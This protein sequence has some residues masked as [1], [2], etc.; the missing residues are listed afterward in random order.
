MFSLVKP[1]RIMFAIGIIALAILSF[2]MHDFIVGRPPAW[3]AGV[4][5]TGLN[6]VLAGI[7]ILCGLAIIFD[8]GGR[9]GAL[10]I[11]LVILISSFLIRYL[12]SLIHA[13]KAEDI[14]W[15]LNAYKTLALAGS[16]FIVAASFPAGRAG[17]NEKLALAGSILLA[18][19]LVLGG[20]SHFH[21]DKFVFDFIPA[22]IP[23]HAFWTYF[24]GVALIAGGIGIVIRPTRYLA[25]LLS[26]IMILGWF[27]L[28]HIPRF[29]S[30]TNDASDRM[31]LCESFAFAGALFVLAAI[32]RRK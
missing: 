13:T 23:F 15:S 2:I 8:T 24:C 9:I 32:S 30:N 17:S 16:A 19:F 1:G 7:C 25:A 31:G 11:G 27:I 12:P 18:L 10:A 3:P 26:G 28:L 4:P 21:F 6:Y 29:Y 22:Y 20:I 14:L 5:S